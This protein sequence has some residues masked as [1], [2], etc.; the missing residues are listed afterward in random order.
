MTAA[1]PSASFRIGNR[2]LHLAVCGERRP[3]RRPCHRGFHLLPVRSEPPSPE[4]ATRGHQESGD[5]RTHLD[6][7]SKSSCRRILGSRR[8][9]SGF[10]CPTR[11]RRPP[12]DYEPTQCI[13][14]RRISFC[15]QWARLKPPPRDDCSRSSRRRGSCRC[16]PASIY[17]RVHD[18][19]LPALRVGATGRSASS[20][21]RSRAVAARPSLATTSVGRTP[22]YWWTRSAPVVTSD[23]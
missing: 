4:V 15:Y 18:C 20:P 14:I 21:T 9:S 1:M 23:R 6:S 8:A 17:R 13:R 10:N 7:S 22:S 11:S 19:T 12:A 2:L 5:S 16:S 3:S